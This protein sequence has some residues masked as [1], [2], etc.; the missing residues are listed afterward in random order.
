MDW[1]RTRTS[2][3]GFPFR[4][5]RTCLSGTVGFWSGTVGFWGGA[6]GFWSGGIGFAGGAVGFSGRAIGFLTIPP[7]GLTQSAPCLLT[8]IMEPAGPEVSCP[9]AGMDVSCPRVTRHYGDRICVFPR[10]Q[11]FFCSHVYGV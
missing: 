11:G 2:S 8:E 7:R 6:V 9:R 5:S 10:G 1:T 3:I 4:K